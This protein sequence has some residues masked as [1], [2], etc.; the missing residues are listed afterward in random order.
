MSETLKTLFESLLMTG[1]ISAGFVWYALVA[2][3]REDREAQSSVPS[4]SART[5]P[6]LNK[7]TR[8]RA[9]HDPDAH[10]GRCGAE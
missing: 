1:A 4:A 7:A 8:S 9:M 10:L 3:R 2:S 6:A 5:V